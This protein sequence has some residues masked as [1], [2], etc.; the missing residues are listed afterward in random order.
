MVYPLPPIEVFFQGNRNGEDS[1]KRTGSHRAPLWSP[2]KY[3]QGNCEESGL[4]LSQYWCLIFLIVEKIKIIR[5]LITL[6]KHLSASL[7][8][9]STHYKAGWH[10]TIK[11]G[12]LLK[13]PLPQFFVDEKHITN[14]KGRAWTPWVLI[15]WCGD[16]NPGRRKIPDTTKYLIQQTGQHRAHT[17]PFQQRAAVTSHY[18]SP[19]SCKMCDS[20]I[21]TL[22]NVLN[23][24]NRSCMGQL[25]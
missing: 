2:S 7:N 19:I 25:S 3:N 12:I 18:R 5:S 13:F 16:T 11:L 8:L 9:I 1:Q 24:W 17:S 14:L 20:D 23:I 21:S 22:L 10:W 6:S 15:G 4:T